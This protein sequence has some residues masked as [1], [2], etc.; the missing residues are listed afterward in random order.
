MNC[1][2]FDDMPLMLDV[3]GIQGILRLVGVQPINL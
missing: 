3:K 1:K 2:S